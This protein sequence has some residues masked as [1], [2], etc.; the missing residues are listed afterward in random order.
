MLLVLMAQMVL[1][2]ARVKKVI[3]VKKD[4]QVQQA[5]MV[6]MVLTEVKDRKVK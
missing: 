5:Q 3:K 1:T 6:Q 2:E 4:K